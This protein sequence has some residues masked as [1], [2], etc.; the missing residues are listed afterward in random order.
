MLDVRLLIDLGLAPKEAEIVVHM[1][2]S[3]KGSKTG[4]F[5]A[6]GLANEVGIPREKIYTYLK[7][8]EKRGVVETIG[9]RPKSFSLRPVDEVLDRLIE[10]NRKNVEKTL[11]DLEAMVQDAKKS[12]YASLLPRISILKDGTQYVRAMID[13]ISTSERVMIIARTSVLLLPWE[14]SGESGQLLETYRRIITDR[15][16]AGKIHVDYFIPFDHTRKEI[17]KRSRESIIDARRAIKNLREFCIENRHPNIVVRNVPKVPAIS[18]IIGRGRVAVGF[19]SEEEARTAKGIL[20][21]SGDFFEFMSSMYDLLMSQPDVSI[22]PVMVEKIEEKL[23][24]L[25]RERI[26]EAL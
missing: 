4:Y 1:A 14:L 13:T 6:P 18:L 9:S 21:E 3:L 19:T 7:N 26:E 17:L 24:E 15:A 22:T 25:G 10:T 8:L 23:N 5:E 11:S 2:G 20:V 16:R 12:E